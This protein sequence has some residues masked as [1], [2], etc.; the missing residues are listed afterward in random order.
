MP[1]NWPYPRIAAH[2]GAGK[3]APENT[4][5]AMRLGHA[6]GYR[7]VEFDVKL[8]ADGVAFLLHDDALDRTTNGRGPADALTWA[9]LAKLDAGSWHSPRFAGEPLPMLAAVARWALDNDVICNVEI[10]P[11]PGRERETGTAVALETRMLWRGASLP[12]LLSS[13]SEEALAAARSA[14]PELQRAL[15]VERIPPDW[16]A[17]L[18]RLQCVALDSDYRE[19]DA[20]VVTEAHDA[21]YRVVTYTPNDPEVVARLVGWGVDCVITDAIDVIRPS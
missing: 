13:F 10:K 18:A 11:M 14:A 17:R 20:R 15:L 21:G 3:L 2:R 12:P 9:A 8:S 4:L 1:D 6:H 19:L 16:Q 5:A 7:M